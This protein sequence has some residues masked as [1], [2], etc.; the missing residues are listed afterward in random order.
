VLDALRVDKAILVG[1][2]Q[3]GWTALKFAIYKP[4]RVE[5]LALICPG[6][7]VP[8]RLSFVVRAIFFALL[9]RR[10]VQRMVRL[11]FA[12]Q[13]V[14]DEVEEATALM[15]RHFNARVGVLPIFSDA[16]LQR[17]TMPT[18]L[19]GGSKDA[20]RD[21]EKIAARLRKLLPHLEVTIVAGGGHA[22]L[23]TTP[24]ILSFLAAE[25]QPQVATIVE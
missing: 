24:R 17:L 15:M 5:K 6:G 12:D 14:P 21:M 8:D 2:S 19:L 25:R 10:G 9:G 1:I 16:E 23:N 3:G 20:L 4:E 18:L 11:I 7:I 22:L 13:P